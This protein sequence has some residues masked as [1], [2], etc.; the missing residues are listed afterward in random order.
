MYVDDAEHIKPMP[1]PTEEDL[2]D[3]VFEAI[4][5]TIKSWDIN[6]PEF[7]DGYCGAN[8]SHAKLILDAIRA[9]VIA[10]IVLKEKP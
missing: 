5:Q 1:N 8:G 4:W 2:K 9:R 3:P 10:E 6:V 7:Y